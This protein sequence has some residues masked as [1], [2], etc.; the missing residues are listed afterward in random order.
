MGYD[1]ISEYLCLIYSHSMCLL[2]DVIE[3]NLIHCKIMYSHANKHHRDQKNK[4]SPSNRHVCLQELVMGAA[5]PAVAN[6]GR[7]RCAKKGIQQLFHL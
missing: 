2:C 5:A 7:L 1:G 4:M 6:T 3:C